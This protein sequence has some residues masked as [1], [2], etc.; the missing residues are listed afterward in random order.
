MQKHG[1]ESGKRGAFCGAML[2]PPT[3]GHL[4]V[5]LDRWGSFM[6]G[7]TEK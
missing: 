5:R 2:V 7:F 3:D 4:E 1:M 6:D